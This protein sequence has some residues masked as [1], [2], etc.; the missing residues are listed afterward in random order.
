MA[1]VVHHAVT[2]Y[3][4]VC[5]LR[6]GTVA[7]GTLAMRKPNPSAIVGCAKIASRSCVYGMPARIAVCTTAITSPA[8]GPIIVKPRMR[9]SLPTRSLRNPCSSQ[10]ACARS[11]A[12]VG[13]FATRTATPLRFAS[14]SRALD[15]RDTASEATIGLRQFEANIAAAEHDQMFRQ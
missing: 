5:R 2:P 3:A 7:F 14:L 9:S 13:I 10:I 15:D 1:D 12:L 8:S 11:T 6:I 4:A